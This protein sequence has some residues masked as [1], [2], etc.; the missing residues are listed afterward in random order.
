MAKKQTARVR[1]VMIIEVEGAQSEVQSLCEG[2]R[3]VAVSLNRAACDLHF[4]RLQD[5]VIPIA[6]T[7]KAKAAI[8]NVTSGA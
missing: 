4:T 8:V 5:V 2:A 1:A 7:R 6:R 3:N